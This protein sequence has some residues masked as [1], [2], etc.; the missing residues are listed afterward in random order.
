MT[1]NSFGEYNA[2]EVK[3]CTTDCGLCQKVCPF[4]VS[5]ENESTIGERL[6]GAIPGIHHCSETGYYLATY[7]GHSE[8]HR[9]TS[10][11]GGAVTCLLETLLSNDAVD[12][13]ICVA[14]TSD[15]EKL[16]EFKVFSTLNEVRTGA[17]SAYYPVE[18]SAAI[19]EVLETPGR[20]AIVGLPCFI[21]AVRLAQKSS[22]KLR[23]RI[24]VTIGLVCGQLKNKHFT[25][26]IASLAGVREKVTGVHYRGKERDQPANNYHFTFTTDGSEKHRIF[27]DEGI[28]E[29]W[30]NR[31]F[32]PEACNYC[33]D[34]FAECADITCMDAW[35]PE[36]SADYRGTSLM[37]VRSPLV[38]ELIEQGHG[39]NIKPISIERVMQSQA[40][41][42]AVKRHQLAY[43]LYLNERQGHTAPVKR[44]APARPK[45]FFLRQEVALKERMRN[46]SHDRWATG[47]TDAEKFR[48]GMRPHLK[49]LA[50]RRRLSYAI[51]L[52]VKALRFVRRRY[53][54]NDNV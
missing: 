17:G 21:K 45:N 50:A 28:S 4:G 27:W 13:V 5:K 52:P 19:R 43:R 23:E 53:G 34:V 1:W 41:V 48:D 44:V 20:Y 15:P 12:H 42:V 31:W 10:A 26:Y 35:L 11:S 54:G 24:I 22:I 49:R 29:A 18:M 51:T 16:F 6:Y 8:K 2:S 36:Y 38:Q 33:D 46:I 37:L 47:L 25:D 40:G 9:P 32:T 39:I 14:P 3:P 7:V 30:T